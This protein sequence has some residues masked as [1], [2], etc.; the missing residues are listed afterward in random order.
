MRWL[1]ALLLLPGPAL[2]DT[3]VASRTIRADT[4]LAAT[5][6]ALLPQDTEGALDDPRLAVGMEARVTLYANRPIRPEDLGPPALVDRNQLVSLSFHSGTLSILTEGRALGRGGVGD[7]IR[8]M[9]LA[10]RTTVT[11]RVTPDGGVI[12]GPNP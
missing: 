10:S 1:F 6:L 8:V 11:G 2:A 7:V 3:V 12:V 4:V 9:N 5:D